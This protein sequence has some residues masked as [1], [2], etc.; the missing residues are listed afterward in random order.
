M[1]DDY[2][3]QPDDSFDHWLAQFNTWCQANGTTHGLT[4]GQLTAIGGLVTAWDYS[5]TGFQNAQTAFH[6]ATQDKDT[7]RTTVEA[8]ARQYAGTINVNPATTNEDRVNAGL[9]PRSSSRTPA[10]I[11]TTTPMVQKLDVSTRAI[12]RIFFADSATPDKRAKP[13]GVQYCEIREQIGGTAPTDPNTMA[14]L[15]SDSRAPYRADFDASDIAKTVYFALRWVNTRHEPGPWS[16]I[17]SAVI[18]G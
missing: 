13:A 9:N 2:V 18:P 6:S 12:V 10:P 17:F 8:L 1:P 14:F 3:P 4:S 5:W 16:A 7:K 15:A 11:P